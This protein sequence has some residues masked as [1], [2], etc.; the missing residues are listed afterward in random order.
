M[1]SEI[2]GVKGAGKKVEGEI[3]FVT[4]FDQTIAGKIVIWEKANGT[5]L[6]K[7]DCLEA[8]GVITSEIDDELFAKIL[9]GK[10]WEIGESV[11]FAFS[12]LVVGR[13]NL[14][15]VKTYIGRKAVLDPAEK[16]LWL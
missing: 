2:T 9:K 3:V 5:A 7:L 12:L 16:R 1:K 15:A 11:H 6:A 8:A 14:A 10:D 4:T 13:E